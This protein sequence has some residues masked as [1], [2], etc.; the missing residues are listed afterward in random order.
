MSDDVAM[1]TGRLSVQPGCVS[2]GVRQAAPRRFG[3]L[4]SKVEESKLQSQ[5]GSWQHG[6]VRRGMRGWEM[7]RCVWERGELQS[8]A[9][10]KPLP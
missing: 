9:L 2:S 7:V 5:M 4:T 3:F 10:D 8:Q 6:E 1:T